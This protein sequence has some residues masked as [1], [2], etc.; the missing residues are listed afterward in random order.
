MMAN[1]NP[2]LRNKNGIYLKGRLDP[3]VIHFQSRFSGKIYR[4]DA[5]KIVRFVDTSTCISVA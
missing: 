1:L 3:N 2:Y 4:L 5:L